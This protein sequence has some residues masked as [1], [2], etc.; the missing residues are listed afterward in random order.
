MY[1]DTKTGHRINDRRM[2]F[3]HIAAAALL[4]FLINGTGRA[5]LSAYA[6][7]TYGYQNNPPYNYHSVGDACRM[8]AGRNSQVNRMLLGRYP[9]ATRS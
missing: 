4:Q 8:I 7:G 1:S 2:T 3:A 5:Q 6:S 9:A